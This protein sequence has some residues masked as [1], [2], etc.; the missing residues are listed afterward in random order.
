MA[1]R[2]KQS[3]WS[4]V[5]KTRKMFSVVVLGLI[6]MST[7]VIVG[8]ISKPQDIRQRA[9]GISPTPVLTSSIASKGALTSATCTVITGWACDEDNYLLPI[10]VQIY[11]GDVGHGTLIG[12]VK[13]DQQGNQQVSDVCGG[14][15]QHAFSFEVPASMKDGKLHQIYAYGMNTPAS[16]EGNT[17]LL[18][19]PRNIQC[20]L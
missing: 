16:Y 13:A 1:K 11:D 6:L 4:S 7:S 9:E 8:V 17:E 20:N 19:S 18:G 12:T 14:N 2:S 3:S 10:D 15:P 5:F